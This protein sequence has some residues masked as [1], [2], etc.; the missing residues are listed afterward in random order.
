MSSGEIALLICG[1]IFVFAIECCKLLEEILHLPSVRPCCP[2][3]AA[4]EKGQSQHI[5]RRYSFTPKR[6][7]TVLVYDTDHTRASKRFSS[8]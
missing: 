4:A 7:K 5:W 6:V 8:G 3:T 2:Q 1:K